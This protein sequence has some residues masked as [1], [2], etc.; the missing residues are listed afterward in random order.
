MAII[1]LMSFQEKLLN[2]TGSE[3]K[4]RKFWRNNCR[5]SKSS[6]SRSKNKAHVVIC[7]L[8]VELCERFA[9]FGI[10]C[11]TILFCTVKLG[12]QNHQA[13][14]VNLCFVG[15]SILMPVFVG[16]FAES[17]MGRIKVVYICIFLH[18]IGTAMLP[19]LAFPFEDLYLD[20]HHIAHILSKREQNIL[21]YI[22]LLATSLGT[23]GVRAI[24]CPLGAYNLQDCRQKELLSFFNWFNWLV[25]LNSF[26]V[27]LGIAYIQ[28]SVAKN[29]GFL[30]P[31][32]S[33]VMALITIH[34]IRTE[35]IYQP[36]KGGSLF[37]TFGVF[38]NALRMCCVQHRHLGGQVSS[39]LDRAKE[40]NG[41]C[42][43]EDHVESTKSLVKLL[44][45]FSFQIL[46]RT[47]V[48]Q[49]PSGYYIQTMNSNLNLNG[50]L[51]P[52][53]AMN[54]I[55]ITPLLV[56]APFL[57]CIN[58]SLLFTERGGLLLSSYIIAGHICASLSMLVAGCFEML[59]KH[60]S[61]VEQTLAGKVLLVS[62][63]PCYHLTPQYLLLGLAEALVTPAC[64]VITFRFVP[65]R[66]RGISMHFLTLFNGAGCFMGV[67][68]V[69][70]VRLISGGVWFPDVLAEGHLQ[71]FFFFLASLLLLNTLAF[72]R[73]SPRYN[74]LG[75]EAEQ[76]FKGSLLEEKLLQHEK[77]LKF[78]DSIWERSSTFTPGETA[79]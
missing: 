12:Y 73:V 48:M 47:C 15:T 60:F 43:S 59:R 55:S 52:I 42:F 40:N 33:V 2:R 44:P 24:I 4:K 31:F 9:F 35:L 53:A 39:W 61:M 20:P 56:L 26:I 54:A 74:N 45:F 71:S 63:M 57:E 1:D 13:A 11:N 3:R 49:I 50:F 16:W 64:S 70:A 30:I 41:G 10:V 38:A 6:G 21:F 8:L 23:G 37:A 67:F 36:K 65:G 51:L 46:Y 5:Q 72:W 79:L 25:N 28:Q 18:F 69:Q 76:G 66:I 17:C 58:G 68:I 7:L 75:E 62:S 14:S 78:Y 29:L 27:F 19:L 77:S 34:M 22:S 32:V